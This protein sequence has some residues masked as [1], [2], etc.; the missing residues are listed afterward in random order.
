[1]QVTVGLITTDSDVCGSL[2]FTSTSI[3]KSDL[4]SATASAT[5]CSLGSTVCPH[6][7]C[8]PPHELAVHPRPTVFI[9]LPATYSC[10]ICKQDLK[11]NF[12]GE[13]G[14]QN[15]ESQM[16]ECGTHT[17]FYICNYPMSIKDYNPDPQ[18][19]VY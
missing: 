6:L 16:V 4:R 2:N 9:E 12:A 5:V 19:F 8:L 15:F 18:L 10:V 11:K 3:R 14:S 17:V 1:M 13:N 7:Q